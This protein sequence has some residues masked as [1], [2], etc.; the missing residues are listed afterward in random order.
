VAVAGFTTLVYHD[1]E[2]S[3]PSLDP[4]V[5]LEAPQPLAVGLAPLM[6]VPRP[7]CSSCT[8]YYAPI[9]TSAPPNCAAC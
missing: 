3:L 5:Y 7:A 8:T 1:I 9:W 2:I 4:Q 6:R